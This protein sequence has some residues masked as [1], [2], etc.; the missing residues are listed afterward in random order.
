M[1]TSVSKS[2]QLVT[3]CIIDVCFSFNTWASPSHVCALHH[4]WFIMDGIHCPRPSHSL[5]LAAMASFFETPFATCQWSN[6]WHLSGL[7]TFIS[8]TICGCLS[9]EIVE[10]LTLFPSMVFRAS[11]K[12]LVSMVLELETW[13]QLITLKSTAFWFCTSKKVYVRYLTEWPGE[14]HRPSPQSTTPP[15]LDF[16]VENT[17][18]CSLVHVFLITGNTN[19]FLSVE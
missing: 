12:P 5:L 8:L 6:S 17:A 16:M 14:S 7:Q 9:V 11:L 19:F 1:T 4:G 2:C 18:V 13:V 3:W 15:S 10:T